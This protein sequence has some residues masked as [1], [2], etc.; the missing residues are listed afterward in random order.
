[1]RF[2]YS[3]PIGERVYRNP[4]ESVQPRWRVR[5]PPPGKKFR[6][7][8]DADTERAALVDRPP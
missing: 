1:L 8:I 2:D 7:R 4:G 5:E 3:H 6:M